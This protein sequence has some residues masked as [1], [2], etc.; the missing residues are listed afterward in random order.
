MVKRYLREDKMPHLWCPGCGNGIVLGSLLRAI[1]KLGLDPQQICV[2]SGIGCSSRAASY[3]KF[4]TLHATH[5]R[6]LAFATGIKLIRPEMKVIVLGG[7][8]DLAAIGASH[9][10]HAARRNI[11]LTTICF[12]NNVYAMTGGQ[13]SPMTPPGALTATTPVQTSERN[14]D[15]CGLV[16]A[17]GATY[18]ARGT[19][20]HTGM[21]SDLIVGAIENK[22]FSFVEAVS[23]CPV[24]YGRYNHIERPSE[25]MLRQKEQAVNVAKAASMPPE[26]LKNKIVVGLLHERAEP[27]YV[28]EYLALVGRAGGK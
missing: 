3:L 22:G 24:Y 9:L 8:G 6:A 18:V 25:M 17:A 14:F 19:A 28:S 26:E 5:G 4:D 10:I 2:V 23:H 15:L 20:Y 11:D 27:E 7:D 1:H 13:H 12:N 16:K 21:L